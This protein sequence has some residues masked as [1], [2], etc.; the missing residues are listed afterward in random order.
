MV[1]TQKE[2]CY[3]KAL[4]FHLPVIWCEEGGIRAPA[5]AK[6]VLESMQGLDE[7]YVRIV[8]HRFYKIPLTIAQSRDWILREFSEEDVFAAREQRLS[9]FWS[10]GKMGDGKNAPV[11]G[12]IFTK[13]Y[14]RYMY[15]F[16]GYGMW[17]AFS[18]NKKQGDHGRVAV[19]GAVKEADSDGKL[20]G[21]AGF[22]SISEEMFPVNSKI[23]TFVRERYCLQAGYE[24]WPQFQGQGYGGQ[25]L[26]AVTEYG[27]KH[28]KLEASVLF[29]RPDNQP[30]QALAR[31]AGY[32][33]AE[34]LQMSGKFV[35]VYWKS[36]TKSH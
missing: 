26:E 1:I 6:Y 15:G 36:F 34:T 13:E 30:S 22:D 11:L 35:K 25:I 4:H 31:K 16:Y 28:L 10:C 21:I 5:G 27:R 17:G 18:Q 12:E 19:P 24:I 33:Y 23:R 29:I 9:G 2:D 32:D 14:I 8:Y 3:E 20:I 7:D